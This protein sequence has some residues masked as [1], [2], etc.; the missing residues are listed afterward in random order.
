MSK[1]LELSDNTYQQL[2]ALA[3]RQ[4]RTMEEMLGFQA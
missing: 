3:Q 2:T 1:V 4:Q